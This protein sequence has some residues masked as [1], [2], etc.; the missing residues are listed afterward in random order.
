MKTVTFSL[1][2]LISNLCWSQTQVWTKFYDTA[3]TSEYELSIYK[4]DKDLFMCSISENYPGAKLNG[5]DL[6]TIRKTD[7]EGNLIWHNRYQQSLLSNYK[8]YTIYNVLFNKNKVIINGSCMNKISGTVNL[9]CLLID[10]NGTYINSIFDSTINYK[11]LSSSFYSNNIL[12]VY[13][14][15]FGNDSIL[16]HTVNYDENLLFLF[17]SSI[18][19]SNRSFL[20]CYND[21]ILIFES[22]PSL[23][24]KI[25]LKTTIYNKQLDIIKSIADTSNIT[26]DLSQFHNYNI[27]S[28]D[29]LGGKYLLQGTFY[30]TK[31]NPNINGLDLDYYYLRIDSTSLNIINEYY[32]NKFN[33]NND[34]EEVIANSVRIKENKNNTIILSKIYQ[35]NLSSS[36]KF[37]LELVD[38][39]Q[40]IWYTY[41]DSLVP[42]ISTSIPINIITIKSHIL[43]STY[44][45]NKGLVLT[46][47]DING[48]KMKIHIDSLDPTLVNSGVNNILAGDSNSVLVFGYIYRNGN[49]DSDLLLKKLNW[50]ETGINGTSH[51][52]KLPILFP[53]PACNKIEL[54]NNHNMVRYE[55][56]DLSGRSVN[57]GIID[58]NNINI[59]NLLPGTYIIKCFT[60]KGSSRNIRFIKIGKE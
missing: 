16:I 14:E 6:P 57:K 3:N 31:N 13:S 7:L 19:K 5:D 24:N 18:P 53:N 56:I 4:I 42:N 17:Q 45:F 23:E 46:E 47:Y 39:G 43:V 22:M 32:G 8:R 52:N 50:E 49:D 26:V 54:L 30:G 48:T 51:Q 36:T 41:L 20:K 35:S 33:A 60:E 12:N 28:I 38:N 25:I 15:P 2:I 34:V 10:T 40:R 21:Q 1:F 11:H 55:I 58:G 27:S 59:E 44:I 29:T 9:Y 37:K